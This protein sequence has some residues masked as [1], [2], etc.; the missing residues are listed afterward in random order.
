LSVHE[1][2]NILTVVLKRFQVI[3]SLLDF[4]RYLFLINVCVLW[5]NVF[6]FLCSCLDVCLSVFD[7]S[8]LKF[9]TSKGS[10]MMIF[11]ICKPLWPMY[12]KLF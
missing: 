3:V 1:V 8:R 5:R 10:W 4:M 2:P 9:L 6:V 11:T 12:L 7:K